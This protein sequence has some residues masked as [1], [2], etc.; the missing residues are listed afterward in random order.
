MTLLTGEASQLGSVLASGTARN[1][2]VS[3]AAMLLGCS[4]FGM[5]LNF[6]QFLCTMHNSALTTTVVGVLKV[7]PA[8]LS[9]NNPALWYALWYA[10]VCLPVTVSHN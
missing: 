4:A 7:C 2:T 3:F 9:E 10:Q 6:S 1:G 5:L 8:G